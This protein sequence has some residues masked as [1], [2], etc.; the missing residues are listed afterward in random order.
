MCARISKTFP[1]ILGLFFVM[2]CLNL[3]A[4]DVENNRAMPLIQ[5]S[6]DVN[7]GV[8]RVSL[9]APKHLTINEGYRTFSID[10]GR[11]VE[12]DFIFT[13][14]NSENPKMITFSIFV[15][16]TDDGIHC[17]IH[18]TQIF[19]ESGCCSDSFSKEESSQVLQIQNN[20]VNM[21]VQPVMYTAGSLFNNS[22][23]IRFSLV[24]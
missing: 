16:N 23:I 1:F 18:E 14:M 5:A 12:S 10:E 21:A 8:L 20:F 22:A 15:K 6:A 11:G 9:K 2:S 19:E 24:P 4:S 3:A 7:D 13:G 17:D